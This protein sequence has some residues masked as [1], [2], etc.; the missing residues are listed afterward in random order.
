[1]V[2]ESKRY[3]NIEVEKLNRMLHERAANPPQCDP[4]TVEGNITWEEYAA[5]CRET[6]RQLE[7]LGVSL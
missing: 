4:F 1:M 3:K 6:E 5:G 2:N 7:S